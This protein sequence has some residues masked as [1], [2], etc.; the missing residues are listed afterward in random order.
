MLRRALLTTALA[1]AACGDDGQ[2]HATWPDASAHTVDAPPPWWQP[3]PDSVQHWDIQ[4][5]PIFDT[6]TSRTMLVFRLWDLVPA[7]TMIDYGDG[8]PV[9]VPKGALAG[10]IAEMHA[11]RPQPKIVCE[12]GTGSLDLADPDA[13]KF[14]GY[15]ASPPD[16][17][18][19]PDAGSVLGWSTTLPANHRWLDIR[20]AAR[21]LIA[22]LVA[23]RLALAVAIGCDGFLP[24]DMDMF[25]IRKNDLSGDPGDGTGFFA[26]TEYFANEQAWYEAVADA[27][28]AVKLSVGMRGAY[29]VLTGALVGKF[30]WQIAD[31]C[32]E[33]G[34]CDATREFSQAH[35]AVL[36]LDYDTDIDG[37]PQN[38][39][40]TCGGQKNNGIGDGIVKN[41]A[42]TSASY[43]A[44][45]DFMTP[46]P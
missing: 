38:V 4:L 27:A 40:T 1:L 15:K 23:K 17:P 37:M 5:A 45:V 19:L 22:P 18:A 3:T 28:H 9:A 29:D 41:A 32:G 44:C 6:E 31:R 10:R 20:P 42:L 7:A 25:R 13:K 30:D 26:T 46:G 24:D 35:K 43:F 8:A 33:F 34:N 2:N 12:V 11:R 16:D 39:G 21:D 14:P 36:A